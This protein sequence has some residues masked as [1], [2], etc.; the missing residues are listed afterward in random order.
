MA[1]CVR[2]PSITCYLGKQVCPARPNTNPNQLEGE[3]AAALL[4]ASADRQAYLPPRRRPST[5]TFLVSLARRLFLLSW[6]SRASAVRNLLLIHRKHVLPYKWSACI[7]CCIALAVMAALTARAVVKSTRASIMGPAGTAA[8]PIDNS[9]N[10][11][12]AIRSK[13]TCTAVC[14]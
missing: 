10:S 1:T 2:F 11:S 8:L 9:S 13:S 3:R 6:S 5:A 4:A 12:L 7:V 14:A